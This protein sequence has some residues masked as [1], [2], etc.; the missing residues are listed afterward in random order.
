MFLVP[1][2]L[3]GI[4]PWDFTPLT[5]RTLC[6]WLMAVG[7]L[8]LWMSRENDWDRVKLPTAMLILLPATLAFQ[9]LRFRD[10][11]VWANA[12]LWVFLADLA[13]VAV[14]L[15][16]LWKPRSQVSP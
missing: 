2:L 11:V 9:L 12:P 4:G 1:S 3:Q 7:L 13:V 5:V 8:Q 16:Y 6:G 15:A 10:Q 14:I